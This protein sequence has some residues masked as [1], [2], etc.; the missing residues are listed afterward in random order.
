MNTNVQLVEELKRDLRTLKAENTFK[1]RIESID[2]SLSPELLHLTQQARD[3][4]ASS[5]L[6]TIPLK[7][8]GLTLNKQEF[9]DS[10]RL[11]YNLPLQRDL[12]S[13]CACGEPFN[14]SHALS[15]KKGEF[16]AQCHDGVRNLLTSLLS[17]VCK[18]VQVEP[19][20]QPLD[21]EVMNLRSATISDARLDVM[22][23]GF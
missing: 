15:C 2:A 13:T 5:W 22:A 11:R 6:N 16:V 10:L 1:V 17:K 3:K 9:R 7:D 18:N 23:G 8:H 21:N 4:G 14:V 20:L 19:H 12:P